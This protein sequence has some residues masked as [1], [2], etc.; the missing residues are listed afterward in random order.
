MTKT[1]ETSSAGRSSEKMSKITVE[2]KRSLRERIYNCARDGYALSLVVLLNSIDDEAL[3]S[4]I[5]NEVKC[6]TTCIIAGDA[7]F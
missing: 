5:L 3:K 7:I 4:R 6:G 2:P 1:T